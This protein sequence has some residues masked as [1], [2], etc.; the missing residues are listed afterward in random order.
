MTKPPTRIL[1]PVQWFGGKGNL[2]SKILPLMPQCQTF[3]DAFGGAGNILIRRKPSPVEVYNDLDQR[4]VNLFRVL[5]HPDQNAQLHHLLSYTLYAKEEYRDALIILQRPTNQWPARLRELQGIY[6][7]EVLDA[8]AFFVG[9]NQGFSGRATGIGSWGTAITVSN[10]GKARTVN[11]FLKRQKLFDWYCQRL[12]DVQIHNRDALEV[13]EIFDTPETLFYLDPPYEHST[14]KGK[15]YAHEQP[16]EFHAA[17]VDRLL[18]LKGS[19]VLS[20]YWH[21]VY[22]PLVDAGWTKLDFAAVSHAAPRT[23]VSGLL[24]ARALSAKVPRTETALFKQVTHPQL[25]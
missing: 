19:A 11:G 12:R 25:F 23:R 3:V 2:H 14:R 6:G 24:G 4:L 1:A 13:I 22:Q 9:Q 15:E 18:H 20:C 8:W 5:K 17:L 10:C 21:P 7:N 16:L